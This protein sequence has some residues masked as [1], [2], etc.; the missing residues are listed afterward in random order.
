M[1]NLGLDLNEFG[2]DKG[3]FAVALGVVFDEDVEGF[4]I[5]VFGEEPTR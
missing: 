5:A 2:V 3:V 1:A 4:G